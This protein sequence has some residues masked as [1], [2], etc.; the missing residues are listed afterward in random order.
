MQK[1]CVK[2]FSR[3]P[4]CSPTVLTENIYA[5]TERDGGDPCLDAYHM[6]KLVTE[7]EIKCH[8]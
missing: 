2:S 6:F 7:T 4:L 5:D 3:V 1:A 8:I